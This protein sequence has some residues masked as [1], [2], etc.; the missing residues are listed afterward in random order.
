MLVGDSFVDV[1]AGVSTL[2]TWG[3]STHSCCA[4]VP[5]D[6]DNGV[7]RGDGDVK[8]G[9]RGVGGAMQRTTVDTT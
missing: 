5:T 7:G 4:A 8:D 1:N 3:T 9:G 6:G 2:P